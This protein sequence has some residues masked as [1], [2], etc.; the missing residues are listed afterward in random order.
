MD[1]KDST[2]TDGKQGLSKREALRFLV[3]IRNFADDGIGGLAANADSIVSRALHTIRS[4]AN[5]A[6]RELL[7]G[8]D[9]D[10]IAEAICAAMREE[11]AADE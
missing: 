6:L 7:S 5:I 1:P 3:R 8:Y 11:G 10:E 2:E 4:E 9:T